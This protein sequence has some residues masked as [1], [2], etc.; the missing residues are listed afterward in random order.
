MNPLISWFRSGGARRDDGVGVA[1]AAAAQAK[2]RDDLVR[3]QAYLMGAVVGVMNECIIDAMRGFY[4]LRK[5]FVILDAI[6]A[7]DADAAG[8][9]PTADDDSDGSLGAFADA[10]ETSP[11][12]P[13]PSVERTEP[14][15]A[16]T[17][18]EPGTA[19]DPCP[20]VPEG[21]LPPPRRSSPAVGGLDDPIDDFIHS[22]TS[23]CLC[24]LLV[25]HSILPP[26]FSCVMSL[27]G[28]RGDRA[29]G[30]RLLWES[31]AH[32]DMHGALSGMLLLAYYNGLLGAVDIVP[33]E[34]DYDAAAESVGPPRR[35]CAALLA[36][37]R[38][39]YPGSRLWRVE[40]ARLLAS[41]RRLDEA[42]EVLRRSERSQMKQL[43]ALEDFDMAI[44][45]MVAQD[46]ALMRD[47]FLR[48]RESSD[49]SPAMYYYSAGCA[50]LELYRDAVQRRR[51][52]EGGV[53]RAAGDDAEADEA[54]R[55]KAQAE[56]LLRKAPQV[57]G[58]KRLMARQL[59]IETFLLRKVAKWE[60]RAARLRLDLADA[61]G[62]S[63]ALELCYV[64][65]GH[66]RMGAGEL[67]RAVGQLSWDRCTA[68][69]EAAARIRAEEDE[70]AVGALCT[71][72]LLCSQGKLD[73]ARALLEDKVLSL[74]G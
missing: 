3:A 19:P 66:R 38:A 56:E 43:A 23:L 64:W 5:A 35:R 46:W 2:Q 1:E 67:A 4:K 18:P 41:Q 48:C 8:A 57:A 36:D 71:A 14:S 47:A 53:A 55:H 25:V 40:E 61:V 73:E 39:R 58:R 6:V 51:S 72:V 33:E 12:P 26:S 52:V 30:I 17:T 45:A 70:G 62:A 27:V 49:W 68:D 60:E 22:G 9:G 15:S 29:K 65:S 59:P 42:I 50:S 7:V 28:F 63:P 34:A 13:S 20:D 74:D 32:H 24:L 54:D 69:G 37:L 16:A 10:R 11:A 21:S 31:A 44:Y